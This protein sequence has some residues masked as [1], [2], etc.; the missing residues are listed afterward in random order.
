MLFFIAK[1]YA[2]SSLMKLIYVK[3][4]F[5]RFNASRVK[6]VVRNCCSSWCSIVSITFRQNFVNFYRSVEKLYG[7]GIYE[8]P[9][10]TCRYSIVVHVRACVFVNRC[11]DL[12]NTTH[13]SFILRTSV[14]SFPNKFIN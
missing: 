14:E 5:A 1:K 12:L 9:S 3:H 10:V 6:D 11:A 13:V 2:V 7:S 8:A 4:R